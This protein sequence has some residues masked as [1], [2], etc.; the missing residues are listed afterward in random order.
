VTVLALSVLTAGN[1]TGDRLAPVSADAEPRSAAVEYREWLRTPWWWYPLG[2]AV[3]SILAAEFHVAGLALTDWI[4]WTGLPLLAVVV[5]FLMG[6]SQLVIAGGELRI[7][8]AHVGL[9]YISDAVELDDRSLRR[10]VGRDGDP[11]SF[12]SIRP[13][14]GPGVQ[15]LLDDADDP[16]PYWVLSTRH[17]EQVVRLLTAG[18]R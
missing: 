3:A 9:N 6:R 12:V 13:W 14:I 15:I 1:G 2:V 8:G 11:T 10:L 18:C 4:P 17:P 16:T 5:T 7:R